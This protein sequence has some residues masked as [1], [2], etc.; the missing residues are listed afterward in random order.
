[1]QLS[2]PFSTARIKSLPGSRPTASARDSADLLSKPRPHCRFCSTSDFF[3]WRTVGIKDRQAKEFITPFLPA[4]A[5]ALAQSRSF[6]CFRRV[7][8][9]PPF[10]LFWPAA[11]RSWPSQGFCSF[12]NHVLG[13]GSWVSRLRSQGCFSFAGNG[14]ISGDGNRRDGFVLT[15]SEIATRC[16]PSRLY[17]RRCRV[18]R[19]RAG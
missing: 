9:F 1:M 2:P 19:R 3:G 8:R 11:P 4:F 12:T 16:K 6:C 18:H 17:R 10:P 5:S 13:S 7:V 14:S 15:L